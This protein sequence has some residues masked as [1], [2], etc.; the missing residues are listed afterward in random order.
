M[1]DP[2]FDVNPLCILPSRQTDLFP[3]QNLYQPL[4]ITKK[5]SILAKPSRK[6]RIWKWKFHWFVTKNY[7][8]NSLEKL[9]QSK[10]IGNL[11]N[12]TLS[13]YSYRHICL[14]YTANDSRRERVEKRKIKNPFLF[15]FSNIVFF[16]ST[17]LLQGVYNK[18]HRKKDKIFFVCRYPATEHY[19]NSNGDIFTS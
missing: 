19:N 13:H 10:E 7:I 12:L 17:T 2:Y 14:F 11:I 6:S 18:T 4:Y 16:H 15:Y 1:I 3:L 5:N 9:N 8:S